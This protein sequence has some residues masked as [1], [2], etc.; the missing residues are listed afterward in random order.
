MEHMGH[1]LLV[2]CCR[3]HLPPA[4]LSESC[5]PHF[6]LQISVPPIPWWSCCSACSALALWV[7]STN[8]TWHVSATYCLEWL[9]SSDPSSPYLLTWLCGLSFGDSINTHSQQLW[10]TV[11]VTTHAAVLTMCHC[12]SLPWPVLARPRPRQDWR[13]QDQDQ[14]CIWQY[15]TKCT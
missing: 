4:A 5:C 12:L 1:R 14:D 2:L 3:L 7:N 6:F 8:V 9:Y 15:E 10:K 13:V 11:P